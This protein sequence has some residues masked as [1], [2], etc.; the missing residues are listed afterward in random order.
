MWTEERILAAYRRATSEN[1]GKP[2]G[3]SQFDKLV[4]E[5]AWRGKYFARFSELVRKAGFSPNQRHERL[6]DAELLQ[7]V[8]ELARTLGRIPTEDERLIARRQ[9]AEFPSNTT[10]R[11]HFKGKKELAAALLA[12]CANRADFEDVFDILKASQEADTATEPDTLRD[13]FVY[14][15]KRGKYYKIGFAANVRG[16]QSQL[17][18]P[19]PDAV[20]HATI[21]SFK[22]DDPRGIEAYWHQRFAEKRREGEYFELTPK[23]VAAFKRRKNFM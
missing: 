23:D 9:N 18:R 16:R 7:P 12:F 8:A 15:M 21:H 1:D 19:V 22:T 2:L 13:G 6:D 17:N 20:P 4:P 10:L 3:R 5:R 11:D 14:L